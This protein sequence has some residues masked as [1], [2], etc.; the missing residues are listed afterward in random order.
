MDEND[1][2]LRERLTAAENGLMNLSGRVD[3]IDDIVSSIREVVVE[4]KQMRSDMN[5]IDRKVTD[6]ENRPAKRW[7]SVVA[8]VIGAVAGGLG[9]AFLSQ[10]TGG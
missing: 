7:E 8:A 5:R 1:V 2:K 10:I 9:T 4:L 3:R 6:I